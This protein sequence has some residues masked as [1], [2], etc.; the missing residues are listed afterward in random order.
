M[1][2]GDLGSRWRWGV[3]TGFNSARERCLI[4][5][6]LHRVGSLGENV[7]ASLTGKMNQKCKWRVVYALLGCLCCKEM[8]KFRSK[9]GAVF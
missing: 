5:K 1:G 3:S 7:G 2:V 6:S 4:G 8:L 9:L